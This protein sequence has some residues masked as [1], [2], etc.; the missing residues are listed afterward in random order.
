MDISREGYLKYVYRRKDRLRL[1]CKK[2][3]EDTRIERDE[4]WRSTTSSPLLPGLPDSLVE[5]K[6]WPHLRRL[7][8]DVD[9]VREDLCRRRIL[10]IFSVAWTSQKWRH[11]MTS[12]KPWV[13]IRLLLHY[14]TQLEN[15]ENVHA[16][17]RCHMMC[18]PPIDAY[19]RFDINELKQECSYWM[20]WT[21]CEETH[22]YCELY[23]DRYDP[24]D[25]IGRILAWRQCRRLGPVAMLD[26]PACRSLV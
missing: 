13:P 26:C 11:I 8:E 6:I 21:E 7:M 3:D 16:Q 2:A 22:V 12:S 24:K 14:C 18:F 4:I 25:L 19:S 5:M 23:I 1:R 20:G 15:P 9:N 10:A 17:F